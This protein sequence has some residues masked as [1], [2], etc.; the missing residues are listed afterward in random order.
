MVL[1]EIGVR[2]GHARAFER[3]QVAIHQR[4]AGINNVHL[5]R[6]VAHQALVL[7][8]SGGEIGGLVEPVAAQFA[9]RM[10]GQAQAE[11]GVL[12]QRQVERTGLLAQ[13]RQQALLAHVQ[14]PGHRTPQN[15]QGHAQKHPYL[16]AQE[17]TSLH[18]RAI[19]AVK[20]IVV[21]RGLHRGPQ[22]AILRP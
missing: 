11:L 10:V 21:V 8:A 2:R 9:Q 6:H 17:Q 7:G 1:F 12:G 5:Q 13:L 4:A 15:G 14:I 19:H 20:K 16:L 18:G 3:R 22:L